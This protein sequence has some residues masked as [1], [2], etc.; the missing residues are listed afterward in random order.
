MAT[1]TSAVIT[2]V[3][4]NDKTV[5][6]A[7]T[8]IN[9]NAD[10]GAIKSLCESLAGLTNNTLSKIQRVDKTDITNA[11]EGGGGNLA[12]GHYALNFFGSALADDMVA[13]GLQT[14]MSTDVAEAFRGTEMYIGVNNLEQD[15]LELDITVTGYKPKNTTVTVDEGTITISYPSDF[16]VTASGTASMKAM[17]IHVPATNKF[18]AATL[19][20]ML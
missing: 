1:K 11:T 12:D 18:K 14:L 15:N 10:N 20:V 19:Y 13:A 7:I 2:G 16:T 9:P 3:D 17:I 8:D 5:S 4:S 6:T